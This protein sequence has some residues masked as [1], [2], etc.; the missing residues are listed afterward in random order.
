V[1][2]HQHMSTRMVSCGSS[3]SINFRHGFHPE[4]TGQPDQPKFT[5]S[6]A[7][8][9]T[10]TYVSR[11]YPPN[12]W[13]ED[14]PGSIHVSNAYARMRLRPAGIPTQSDKVPFPF[15]GEEWYVVDMQTQQTGG[16][17]TFQ[18]TPEGQLVFRPGFLANLDPRQPEFVLSSGLERFMYSPRDRLLHTLI[19][20]AYVGAAAAVFGALWSAHHNLALVLAVN[21]A[22]AKISVP[23]V[24]LLLGLAWAGKLWM[25]WVF[26]AGSLVDQLLER[27]AP[28]VRSLMWGLFFAWVAY[29]ALSP[30]WAY[31]L[32][33]VAPGSN[34]LLDRLIP[35]MMGR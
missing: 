27:I 28:P 8:V 19:A 24:A 23:R 1:L 9:D 29:M 2:Q 4:Q 12:I 35:S 11:A 14:P 20:A 21:W 10:Q 25:Y 34:L 17:P 30:V 26:F 33:L 22:L 3:Q 6:E 15:K 7:E 16:W 32:P 5:T 31:P 18:R 13:A